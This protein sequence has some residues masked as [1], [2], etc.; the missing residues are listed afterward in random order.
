M[1]MNMETRVHGVL[2][3]RITFALLLVNGQG[4]DRI[5]IRI[6]ICSALM[7]INKPRFETIYNYIYIYT[8]VHI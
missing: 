5:C 7:K 3:L 1:F 4:L 8:H 2:L 6:T